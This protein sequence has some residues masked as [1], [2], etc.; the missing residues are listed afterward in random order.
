MEIA[1][2]GLGDG[3]MVVHE[4]AQK[5]NELDW[6]QFT[7]LLDKNEKEIFEGDMVRFERMNDPAGEKTEHEERVEWMDKVS[8][9]FPFADY[10]S[11]CGVEVNMNTV[12]IIGNTYEN[13]VRK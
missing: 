4:D 5:G 6:M 12:E 13:Q 2:I 8:G 9:F 1:N 3:S 10:D 7:G 11:D